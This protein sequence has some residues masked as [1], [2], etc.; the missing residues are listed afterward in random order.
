MNILEVDQVSKFYT[1]K[2]ALNK[3]SIVIPEGT[4]YGLLGPNGAGKTTLIRIINQITAPDEGTVKFKGERLGNKHIFRIGYLPEERGLYKKME[5]AD[6]M[7]YFAQLKGLTRNDAIKRTKY[8]F[9]KFEIMSWKNKKI[10]DLSKGM[11]Q[12]IQFIATIIHQPELLILDEPFTGL[13]PINSDLIRDE[14]LELKRQGTSV[15]LST[16]RMES[17]ETLCDSIALLNL[18]K[19]VLDGKTSEIKKQ[20]SNNSFT[21]TLAGHHETINFTPH[22]ELKSLQIVGENT[23]VQVALLQGNTNAMLQQLLQEYTIIKFA[24]LIP[25]INDIFKL[26]VTETGGVLNAGF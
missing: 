11:Q 1:G 6:Q 13:D 5:I 22:V 4:I 2:T 16:H 3:V 12:K 19:K 18:S 14:I 23:E 8:W 26:K 24:E 15:V 20:F 21:I 25:T 17:V 10:E 7:L 9:E